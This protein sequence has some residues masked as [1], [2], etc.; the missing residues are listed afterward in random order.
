MT[1]N[2][3]DRAIET[4]DLVC[5]QCANVVHVTEGEKIPRCPECGNDAFSE[6]REPAP[7][8]GRRQS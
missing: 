8:R 6:L 2:A 1:A 3:G 5:D 4:G 7:G